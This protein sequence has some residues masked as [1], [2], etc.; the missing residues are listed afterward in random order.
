MHNVLFRV[1]SCISTAPYN[2]TSANAN[3]VVFWCTVSGLPDAHKSHSTYSG[4]AQISSALL[5]QVECTLD[6]SITRHTRINCVAG[7]QCAQNVFQVVRLLSSSS[8]ALTRITLCAVPLSLNSSSAGVK[9]SL[10]YN[11]FLPGACCTNLI[12]D[13]WNLSL[14]KAASDTFILLILGHHVFLP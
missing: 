14:G 7:I 9:A 3:P 13:S 10:G 6:V 2:L 12:I 11:I 8:E 5:T 4:H 1:T